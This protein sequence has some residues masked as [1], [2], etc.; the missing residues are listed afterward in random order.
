MANDGQTD[1]PSVISSSI[2]SPTPIGALPVP[3]NPANY[4]NASS[5]QPSLFAA[6]DLQGSYVVNRSNSLEISSVALETW[7]QK[8]WRYQQQVPIGAPAQ[9]ASL[10]DPPSVA[11]TDTLNPFTLPP[12][13]TQFWRWTASD[14]GVSAL[15]FV[16][17]YH[18]D[19]GSKPLMLYVGETGQSNQRWKGEHGCK[20]YLLSYQQAH[21]DHDLPTQL[22]IAFWQDA[23]EGVAD[24][25]S[26]ESALIAKWKSPFNKENWRFWGTPFVGS[27]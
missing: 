27:K 6:Q 19:P 13:N 16:F 3:S 7:K 8:I 12:Q 1:A 20:R 15:Y 11:L 18:R 10:F 22:G 26:L 5:E 9:Q 24:R 25:Q 14:A 4:S 23:P 2:S 21:Y 17:D